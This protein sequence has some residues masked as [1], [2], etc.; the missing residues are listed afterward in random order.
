VDLSGSGKYLVAS[1]AALNFSATAGGANPA[2]QNVVV[3]NKGN[4][5][6]TGITVVADPAFSTTTDCINLTSGASCTVSVTF[7]TP[8][9]ATTVNGALTI[10]YDQVA[11]TPETVALTGVSH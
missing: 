1:P 6:V 8:A 4:T 9:S 10:T 7:L 2:R 3:T 5:A 11:N